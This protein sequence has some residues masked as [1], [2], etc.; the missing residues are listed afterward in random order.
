MAIGDGE[1]DVEMLEMVG[2]SIFAGVASGLYGLIYM[3]FQHDICECKNVNSDV[4]LQIF[5]IFCVLCQLGIAVANAGPRA[6]EAADVLV[7]SN[8]EDGVAEAIKKY[9]L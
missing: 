3:I 7:S 1:N 6:Q 5:D 9:V 4:I 2:V 8:D